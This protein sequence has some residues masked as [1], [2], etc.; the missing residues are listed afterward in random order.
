MTS[1]L[2][3]IQ[4]LQQTFLIKGSLRERFAAGVSWSM[5]GAVIGR[6]LTLVASMVTARLLGKIG[7][8]EL[9]MIQS[10]IGMLGMFA[11]LGLGMT[12]TKYVA[13]FRHKD[14]VRA[15]HAIA[16][17]FIV[18]LGSGGL[19]SLLLIV[20]APW[21]AGHTLAA[22]HLAQLLQ[23]GS[24]LLFFSA[25]SGV[26]TGALSGFEAFKEIARINIVSGL[27]SFPLLIAG[28]VLGGLRG[29]VWALVLSLALS[30]L[31]NHFAL[32]NR[33]RENNIPLG[34]ARNGKEWSIL[35]QFSLPAFLSGIMVGPVNWLCSALIVNQ[36]HGYAEMGILNAANQWRN[37]ILFLPAV[38]GQ[39]LVPLLTEKISL[40]D[41]TSARKIL[42]YSMTANA[43]ILS[44]IVL[45]GC[46]F[47]SHIMSAYGRD[48]SG[49]WATLIIVLVTAGLLA[50]QTPVGQVIAA[51]GKMWLGFLMNV[52]WAAVTILATV[53]LL[54]KGALGLA[55]GQLV[56]YS[57][58]GIWTMVFAYQVI[59]KR[60]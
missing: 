15:G 28:A 55:I 9:G 5:A 54:R 26:Q 11:G 6:G 7:F 29:S 35:W 17:S 22:P 60:D 24:G 40:K 52:G 57:I 34:Y 32:R 51:S 12:A 8:G 20:C 13:E 53:L 19:I 47:S 43:L 50:V 56:G 46:F 14:P 44:P 39:V 49:S 23:I 3:K 4:E 30:C 38:F 27:L 59:N 16:L 1:A 42:Y 45:A 18:A 41:G 31:L 37:A 33:I 10:T 25:L 2:S 21:L 48:F 58:H 36:P